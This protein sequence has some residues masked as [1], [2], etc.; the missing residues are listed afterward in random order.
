M[1]TVSDLP[2]KAGVN[3]PKQIG[4]MKDEVSCKVCEHYQQCLR[5]LYAAMM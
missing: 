2:Q 3:C 4:E 1:T 5:Q